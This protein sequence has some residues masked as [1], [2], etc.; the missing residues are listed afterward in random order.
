MRLIREDVHND[1]NKIKSIITP[2]MDAYA[3]P[4]L[5]EIL[6][7]MI[8]NEYKVTSNENTNLSDKGEQKEKQIRLGLRRRI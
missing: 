1:W 2:N 3:L 6:E 7:P 4:Y 8:K 5:V